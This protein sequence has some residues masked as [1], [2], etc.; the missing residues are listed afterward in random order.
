LE[1]LGAG[2]SKYRDGYRE[3]FTQGPVSKKNELHGYESGVTASSR[4]V[5]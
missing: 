1:Y 3:Q 5:N 4:A 2:N